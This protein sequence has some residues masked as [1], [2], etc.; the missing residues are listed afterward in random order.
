LRREIAFQTLTSLVKEEKISPLQIEKT[1]QKVS[2]EID[3]LIIKTGKEALDE[4]EI[5]GVNPELVKYLGKLKYRT[6]Y[7][8]NVLEHCLEVALL[9]GNIATELNLDVLLARRAGLFHDIG[10]AVEEKNVSHVLSGVSL[11]KKYSEPEEVINE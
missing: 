5:N 10:K 7:G 9:A 4:L 6:S 2:S 8:Q 3:Q 11:A 1:Y